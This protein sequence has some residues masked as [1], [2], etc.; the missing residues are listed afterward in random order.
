[1]TTLKEDELSIHIKKMELGSINCEFKPYFYKEKSFSTL[2]KI[3]QKFIF[4]DDN[5]KKLFIE[6]ETI[7]DRKKDINYQEH[8]QIIKEMLKNIYI[9]ETNLGRYYK[10]DFDNLSES[11]NLYFELFNIKDEKLINKFYGYLC[12]NILYVLKKQKDDIEVIYSK[13]LFSILQS[14]N[15]RCEKTIKKIKSKIN[16]IKN[17][18]IFSCFSVRV[19]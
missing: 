6:W 13:R 17:P 4:G 5:H 12:E 9:E 14:R 2:P 1:M 18:G 8:F 15:P 10:E 19:P 11:F 3:K 7:S 16:K